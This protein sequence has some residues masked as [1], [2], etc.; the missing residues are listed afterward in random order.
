[1]SP[2]LTNKNNLE[3]D[4]KK[5]KFSFIDF[6]RVQL[7]TKGHTKKRLFFVE[8]HIALYGKMEN[9]SSTKRKMK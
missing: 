3:F 6:K 7:R 5:L 2:F 9:E 8:F 1:M 4:P